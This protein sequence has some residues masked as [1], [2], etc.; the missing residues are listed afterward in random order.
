MKFGPSQPSAGA[1]KASA[2]IA[3]IAASSSPARRA[4][5]RVGRVVGTRSMVRVLEAS[6]SEMTSTTASLPSRSHRR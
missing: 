6:S 3:W 1:P 2:P 4:A 5:S